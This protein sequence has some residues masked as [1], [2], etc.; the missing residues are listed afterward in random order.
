MRVVV[1]GG[2]GFI[3][4]RLCSALAS[5]GDEVTVLTRDPARRT[6]GLPPGVAL[7]SWDAAA[8][9][10]DGAAAIVNLAGE[11]VA[12]RWTPDVKRTILASRTGALERLRAAVERTA[13]RPAVLVSASAVGFFGA[14]GEEDLTESSPP[15]SDFLATTCVRW[16]QAAR[17]VA[18]L[19]PRV[20]TVRIGLVLGEDGGALAKMLPAFRLGGG[21]PI[22]NG[23]QWMSWVHLD[24]L[25]SLLLFALD[26]AD[27]PPV[28]HAT[29]PEP[30]R[31]RDFTRALGRALHRP[32]FVPAPAFALRLA[33]G[34]MATL[35]LDGQKVLPRET[36]AAGFCFRFGALPE[37]L[38]AVV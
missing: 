6:P 13:S 16:E 34:E 5:R 11:P 14:R 15:G 2:T 25:V 9:A 23:L 12:Q 36:T 21:G 4:R 24:D 35:L 30:V 27:A 37:A 28:L 8:T 33:F 10:V 1:T 22:G 26:R 17:A 3:G 38:A 19:G 20:S 7:A 18:P 31:N 29:A 32:A